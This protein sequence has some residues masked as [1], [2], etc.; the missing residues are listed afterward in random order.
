[1][2][3]R[4]FRTTRL[5]DAATSVAA[6]LGYLAIAVLATW[7]LCRNFFSQVAGDGTDPWQTLWGFWWWRHSW[8]FGDHPMRTSLLWWPHGAS[9]WFQTFDIPS[10]LL[11][12][13]LWNW[14]PEAGIYNL[15]VLLSFPASGLTFYWLCRE[16]HRDK[17]AAALAGCI[18]TFSTYHYA[19]ANACLHIASMQWTPLYLLGLHRLVNRPTASAAL[20]AG[21][22]FALA[23][24]T[25]PYHLL[26]CLSA[27]GALA[28]WYALTMTAWPATGGRL[29]KRTALAALVGF[30]LAGWLLWG[31][32][33][34]YSSGA[35]IGS[36]PPAQFSADLE[37]F[38]LPNAVSRWAVY[39]PFWKDWLGSR[40]AGAT[41]LWAN[42][43]YV[44]YVPLALASLAWWRGQ[45]RAW[46][47]V[48]GVG[49]VVAIGPQLQIG[50][51]AYGGRMPYA[52]LSELVPPLTF[53][54][55]P[56]R[57][58]WLT[59][60]GVAVAAC[61][62]LAGLSKAGAKGRA[63]AAGLTLIALIESWPRPMLMSA[64]PRPEFLSTLAHDGGTW[65][66]L[67][68]T[69]WSRALW[70]QTRHR[71]PIAGGYLTRP[72]EHAWRELEGD[73]ALSP[74]VGH[75][76]KRSTSQAPVGDEIIAQRL[77]ELKFRYLIVDDARSTIPRIP[78][79]DRDQT[80]LL[81]ASARQRSFFTTRAV[82]Q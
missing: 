70:H 3:I 15:P 74:F 73:P 62:T 72:P 68:A 48:A 33:T 36:H 77:R 53:S 1:V 26:F 28:G 23:T 13:P 22:G 41:G 60:C 46:L 50:G 57:F 79:G 64:Y 12:L 39:T 21:V 10:A 5:P 19:H 31:M 55:I 4:A 32:W 42:A 47:V 65:A 76:F 54:G 78:G 69:W 25:S 52:W 58:A 30:A 34:S 45:A 14:M 56:S 35:F 75:L 71:H 44:G 37:S 16:L 18:Y 2:I 7:P 24:L 38:L 49:F 80:R 17:L 63:A 11:V 6:F 67:D 27:T 43:A 59:G 51:M 20:L 8:E 82:R 61:A 9:L 81:E 66:V 29:L 40:W